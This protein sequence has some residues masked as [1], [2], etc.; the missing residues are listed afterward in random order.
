MMP[1]LAP[2]LSDEPADGKGGGKEDA[3]D[4]PGMH[5]PYWPWQPC[6]QKSELFPQVSLE[7]QQ[8]PQR[9]SLHRTGFPPMRPQELFELMDAA[10]Q[11]PNSG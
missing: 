11:I 3:C 4:W 9:L 1:A 5:L 8:S 2:W 10:P 7:A 6:S